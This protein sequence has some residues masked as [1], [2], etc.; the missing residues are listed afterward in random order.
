MSP[1]A[2]ETNDLDASD[3]NGSISYLELSILQFILFRHNVLDLHL[4]LRIC[5]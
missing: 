3:G 4:L 2:E 5:K 1:S